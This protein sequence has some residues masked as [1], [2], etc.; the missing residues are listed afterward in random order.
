MA[1][2]HLKQ[3][4]SLGKLHVILPSFSPNPGKFGLNMLA[5]KFP[6]VFAP[7]LII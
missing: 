4:L 3:P 6:P 5:V 2:W 1:D 7:W